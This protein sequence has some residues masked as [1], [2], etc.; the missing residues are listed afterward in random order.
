MNRRKF[1]QMAAVGAASPF[2]ETGP[3]SPRFE[4]GLPNHHQEKNCFAGALRICPA[5]SALSKPECRQLALFDVEAAY[6]IS[7]V[8]R[9]GE[10]VRR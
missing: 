9:S 2:Q 10:S 5:C 3:Y 6:L 7:P 1:L 8:K 4:P